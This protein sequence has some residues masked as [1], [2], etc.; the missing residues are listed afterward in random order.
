MKSCMKSWLTL[1]LPVSAVPLLAAAIILP[2]GGQSA[3][4]QNVPALAKT[5]PD[6]VAE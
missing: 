5:A 4:K 6:K 3:H 2:S 1:A